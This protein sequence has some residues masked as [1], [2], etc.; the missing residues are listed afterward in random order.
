MPAGSLETLD[1]GYLPKTG[2]SRNKQ[3]F[4]NKWVIYASW[5]FSQVLVFSPLLEEEWFQARTVKILSSDSRGWKVFL[6]MRSLQ[7]LPSLL[8]T[9]VQSIFYIQFECIH[10]LQLGKGPAEPSSHSKKC[11][12]EEKH[13]LWGSRSEILEVQDWQAH[14]PTLGCLNFKENTSAIHRA[15]FKSCESYGF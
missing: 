5:S 6:S 11:G 2:S 15:H 14:L 9:S 10:N 4:G 7:W 3:L 12:P 13:H 1:V 8:L